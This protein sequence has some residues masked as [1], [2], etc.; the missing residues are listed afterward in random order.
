MRERGNSTVILSPIRSSAERRARRQKMNRIERIQI[1]TADSR[2]GNQ[3]LHYALEK[4]AWIWLPG[5]DAGSGPHAV[6]FRNEWTAEEEETLLTIHLSADTRFEAFLD[7]VPFAMGPDRSDLKHWSFSSFRICVPRG[8]HVFEVLCFY[9]PRPASPCAR[10]SREPGFIF[11]VSGREDADTDRRAEG[12][13]DRHPGLPRWPGKF[14]NTG[15]EQS[16]WRVRER[17]GVSFFPAGNSFIAAP[18]RL[19]G[20]EFYRD[21]PYVSPAVVR[22]ALCPNE[23]GVRRP[24]WILH[25]SPLP[26]QMRAVYGKTGE[27]RAYFDGPAGDCPVVEKDNLRPTAAWTRFQNFLEG[28]ETLAVPPQTE[29]SVLIDLHDY[30]C[31]FPELEAEGGGEDAEIRIAWQESLYLP[32]S[33]EKGNRD[34]ICGKCFPVSVQW[35]LFRRLDPCRC[36]KYRSVS[37]RAGRYLLISVKTGRMELRLHRLRLLETRY[38]LKIESEIRFSEEGLNELQPFMIRALESCMHETYMDCPYH[39]QLMYVGDTRL[40]ALTTHVLSRDFRLPLR[41]VEL[42]DWSRSDWDGLVAERYPSS[43]PQ[44]SVTFSLL[45]PLMLRDL[46]LYR[47]IPAEK[48]RRLRNSVRTMLLRVSEYLNGEDLLENLPGWS[49]V[50]WCPEWRVGVPYPLDSGGVSSLFSLHFVLSLKAALELEQYLPGQEAETPG[51]RQEEEAR[52]DET[53]FRELY[54]SLSERVSTS[55]LRHFWTEDRSML[56]DDLSREHFSV[57]AQCLALL[58]GVLPPE[59]EYACLEALLNVKPGTAAFP[60][61]Y[62]S[63]YFFET[64]YRFHRA[65]RIPDFLGIWRKM[66]EEGGAVTTWESPEPSRSDCH[67]WGAHPLYHFYSSVAGIRSTAPGFRKVLITPQMGKMKQICGALTHPDGEIKFDFRNDDGAFHARIVLPENCEG[68]FRLAS[69]G[70]LLHPGENELNVKKRIDNDK[71]L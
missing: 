9:L 26:E 3:K 12:E 40:E 11:G 57:H 22:A 65:D 55:L 48:F 19:D 5:R 44:L 61:V 52:T 25:P 53:A 67:A 7:G 32:G 17:P 69:Y 31:A 50:D 13:K 23:Y 68:I 45:W 21:T 27:L 35:D 18:L 70:R 30:L 1:Q 8:R 64:L 66:R 71:R 10:L 24:G 34:E 56:A 41:A 38:P 15:A 59:K 37:W 16:S 39:E 63:H 51:T 62:F 14:L 29:F 49:F 33:R 20:A 6:E 42:F 28:K 58:S 4:S 47:R 36:R 54:R 46:A 43:E 2:N 60:T